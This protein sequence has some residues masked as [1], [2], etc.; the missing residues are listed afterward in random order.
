M[1]KR[2][3]IKIIGAGGLVISGFGFAPWL[4]GQKSIRQKKDGSKLW[5]W[6]HPNDFP[7]TKKTTEEWKWLLGNLKEW[8]IADILLLTRN[9]EILDQVLPVASRFDIDIH[10]WI[11]S[12]EYPDEKIMQNH[13][14]WYVINAN[15]ESCI[16][17]PAYINDYRWL[18]PSNP[19]VIG[20]I[21][22]RVS[23]LCNYNELAG[24]H[25]D[26]IRYPDVV[27]APY[28]RSKYDIPQDDLIHPQF[29]YCYCETCRAGFKQAEGIDP[30]S[31]PDT[32]TNEKWLKFRLEALSNLV[33]E[34][35]QT[36]HGSKKLITAAVFP[37]PEIS[38]SRV[39][40]DW[41]GWDLDA[42]MPMIYQRYE[43]QPVEWIGRA[44]REGVDALHGRIPLYSGLHLSQLTPEE[45]GMAYR[46]STDAGAMGVSL[47]TGNK[48]NGYYRQ[49][50]DKTLYK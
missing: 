49:C 47:F 23:M 27:L 26:Y 20:F 5:A 31:L 45:L 10:A 4:A 16:D 33:N 43:S 50:M 19:E 40:Q 17:K 14:S 37:T 7:D 22:E 46:L 6:V 9:N 34:I 29:D 42:V 12:L 24:I 44:T 41:A 48:M 2:E 8:G 21:K 32:L 15:G 11:I 3:F 38:I 25:L 1:K 36:A 28:H 39:R 35:S 30:L 13:P 18:C